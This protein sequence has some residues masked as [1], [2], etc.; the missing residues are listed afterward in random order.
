MVKQEQVAK[1]EGKAAKEPVQP[2]WQCG[3][4]STSNRVV[5]SSN[6]TSLCSKEECSTDSAIGSRAFMFTGTALRG[7]RAFAVG[8]VLVFLVSL[9]VRRVLACAGRATHVRAALEWDIS[10]GQCQ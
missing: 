5:E 10:P 2:I 8:D 9:R 7:P 3:R 1:E 4:Q 6:T